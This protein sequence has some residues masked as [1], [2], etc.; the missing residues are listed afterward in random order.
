MALWVHQRPAVVHSFML[1]PSDTL[2]LQF[3]SEKH[4]PPVGWIVSLNMLE[5]FIQMA[6][7][8]AVVVKL[9]RHKNIFGL[10]C[11]VW[12]ESTWTR[13]RTAFWLCVKAW[14]RSLT[15]VAYRL[16]LDSVTCVCGTPWRATWL[17]AR[18]TRAGSPPTSSLHPFQWISAGIVNAM[19]SPHILPLM[20]A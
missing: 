7:R 4:P 8:T 9:D 3:P 16:V 5:R 15:P 13:A 14:R 6:L 12:R 2:Q 18:L 19:R 11:L 17:N 1:V 10:V 20:S